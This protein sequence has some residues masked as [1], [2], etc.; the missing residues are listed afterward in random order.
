M[1]VVQP[2]KDEIIEVEAVRNAE[3]RD[4]IKNAKEVLVSGDSPPKKSSDKPRDAK[5]DSEA[6]EKAGFGNFW[7]GVPLIY[8]VSTTHLTD[9]CG[10]RE[11]CHMVQN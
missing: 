9:T 8:L 11:S 3:A 6:E 1:S 2:P 10:N 7:V 5:Y 4:D